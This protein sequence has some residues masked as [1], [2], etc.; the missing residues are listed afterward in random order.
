M[1]PLPDGPEPMK[2]MDT[3]V[4]EMLLKADCFGCV[5]RG[6]SIGE[7][8]E[9]PCVRRDLRAAPWWARPVARSLAR[10]EAKAFQ[11]WGIYKSQRQD[12]PDCQRLWED[13][14]GGLLA[15]NRDQL[16]RT[17][18]S[19]EPMQV[20][21]PNDPR[22]FAEAFRLLC[23]F[24]RAGIAHNDLAKEPNWLV[25]TDG[26]PGLL[27]FQL[28]RVFRKRTRLFRMMAREDIRH[29]LKHK[30]TY[31][32]EALTQREIQILSSP[33][34]PA[35]FWRMTGKRVYWFVTRKLMGWSDREGAGNRGG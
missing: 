20:A 8:G 12:N 28:A 18:V 23:Q 3:F 29:L 7:G 33:S 24:H 4:S 1:R 2:A 19:G 6:H 5:E 14:I 15:F 21:R 13:S 11:A 31:C 34:F 16:V 35:R 27:D 30:R 9:Y 22:Y 25:L 10:R 26:R 17:W 32:R